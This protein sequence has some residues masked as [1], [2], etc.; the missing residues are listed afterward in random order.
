MVAHILHSTGTKL[1]LLGQRT[2]PGGLTV[3]TLIILVCDCEYGCMI[4]HPKLMMTSSNGSIFRV[5]EYLCGKFTGHRWIPR[6]KASDAE[7][8]CLLWSTL[9][10]WLS[11]QWWGWWFET[12]SSPLWPHCNVSCMLLALCCVLSWCGSDQFYSYSPTV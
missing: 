4:L 6:T 5:T 7:L 9:N 11:K 8:W 1:Q 2:S 12:P 10:K 3:Y